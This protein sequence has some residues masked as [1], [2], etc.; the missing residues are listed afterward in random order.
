MLQGLFAAAAPRV[1]RQQASHHAAGHPRSS[2]GELGAAGG[3]ERA[4]ARVS[5]EEAMDVQRQRSG[6]EE[7]QQVSSTCH[8][9]CLNSE[10]ATSLEVAG[11]SRG[12][13]PCICVGAAI[14]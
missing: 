8:D 5:L 12:S 6:G 11:G 10:E 9:A 7:C 2:V 3:A 1:R 4:A 14:G 13:R